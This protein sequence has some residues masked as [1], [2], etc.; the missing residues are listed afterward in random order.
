MQSIWE[1]AERKVRI[2]SVQRS[3]GQYKT[4]EYKWFVMVEV[5]SS[6][7]SVVYLPL[8]EEYKDQAG[9]GRIISHLHMLQA[10]TT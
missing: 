8:E 7:S 2:P 5:Q 10:S 9:Q 6:F 1:E 4:S 3:P